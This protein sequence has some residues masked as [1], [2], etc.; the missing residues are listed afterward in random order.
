MPHRPAQVWTG[1]AWDDIGDSRLITH[2]HAGGAN[3]AN[4]P[5]SSVTNLTSDLGS[6]VDYAMPANAQSGTGASAYTFALADATRLTTATGTSAKTF[7][8]PPQTSVTWLANSII[9]V[10]NYGA[11][12]L[13]IAGGSGVTVT[14]ATKT[15]AQFESAALIRT[16]SNAWTLVPFSGGAGNA[17]FSN[18]ATG[19]YTDS[20][21][22][23]KY[24]TF[25]ASGTLTVTREGMA[26]VFIVGGGGSGGGV[27][28][29]NGGGGGGGGILNEQVRLPA[30]SLT[31]VVGGGGAAPPAQVVGARGFPSYLDLY[32]AP[33]GGGGGYGAAGLV[34]GSGGGGSS[35][36]NS[37]GGGKVSARFIGF[38]GGAGN[39]AG[40]RIGGGGGGANETGN[41]DGQGYGGDGLSTSIT[42]TPTVYAGGGGGGKNNPFVANG[43][44]GGGGA[45]GNS[46]SGA[47]AGTANRGGGGGGGGNIQFT[48]TQAGAAGG[49]GIVIVRVRT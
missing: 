22:N 12:D 34:G 24:L 42:N 7:T 23:Y 5:Q 17:D 39:D 32:S 1:T 29:G 35:I 11:G 31:V 38:N 28:P 13:T 16:A 26:D 46:D 9:R 43:G 37:A 44:D 15:L 8:I 3:G 21:I 49:S 48:T 14:N 10:A 30:G 45:G 19:T 6:K 25:T 41:T 47:T 27:S 36:N 18:A 33:G 4:I 2:T 20:G 40:D